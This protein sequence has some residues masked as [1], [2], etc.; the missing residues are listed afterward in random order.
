VVVIEKV[1]WQV[2]PGGSDVGWVKFCPPNPILRSQLFTLSYSH[3]QRTHANARKSSIVCA[4]TTICRFQPR[5]LLPS[6]VWHRV[7]GA[8]SDN[9]GSTLV[10]E[11]STRVMPP[12]FSTRCI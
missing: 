9:A 12:I 8:V 10:E 3:S 4:L 1:S 7:S 2:F 6:C 11:S 5:L